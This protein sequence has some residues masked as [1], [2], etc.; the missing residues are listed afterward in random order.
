MTVT[1]LI[2]AA[3]LLLGGVFVVLASAG[4][5]RFDDLYSRIHAATKAITLGVLL[6]IAAA[7]FRMDDPANLVKLLLAAILQMVGAPVAGHMLGRAAYGAGVRP[8]RHTAVDHLRG[9]M[10]KMGKMGKVGSQ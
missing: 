1:D 4:L 8:S 9:K 6:V 2:A 7:A 5:W 3:L 10:G